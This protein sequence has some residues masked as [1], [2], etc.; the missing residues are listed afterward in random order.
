V[1]GIYFPYLA[2]SG[3]GISVSDSLCSLYLQ[4]LSVTISLGSIEIASVPNQLMFL[5]F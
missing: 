4:G 2:L 5:R 1:D 3:K